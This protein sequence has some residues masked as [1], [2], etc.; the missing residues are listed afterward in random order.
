MGRGPTPGAPNA[1]HISCWCSVRRARRGAPPVT[2]A[3]K[4]VRVARA[5]N[6]YK[7]FDAELKKKNSFAIPKDAASRGPGVVRRSG[8]G[9]GRRGP[10]ACA[11]ELPRVVG[12]PERRRGCGGGRARPGPGGFLRGR[13]GADLNGGKVSASRA[14]G[15]A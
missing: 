2:T 7:P 13:R 14:R 5:G 11:A 6:R 4:R 12:G 1:R 9:L 8:S 15:R 3:R 10:G